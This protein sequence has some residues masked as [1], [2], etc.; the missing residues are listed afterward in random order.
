LVERLGG[1]VV[2]LAFLMELGFLNGRDKVGDYRV[3][4]VLQYE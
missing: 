3:Q 2:G 4:T 1:T